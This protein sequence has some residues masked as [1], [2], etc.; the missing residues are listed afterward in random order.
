MPYLCASFSEYMDRN[1]IIGFSLL[2]LLLI[3]Y[4]AYNQHEQKVFFEAKKADSIAYAR[5]HPRPVIDSSRAG[6]TAQP[7]STDSATEALR[8]SQPAAYFGQEQQV[9]LQNKKLSIDFS[10]K[11]AHPVAAKP[12]R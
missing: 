1:Q 5:T 8:R 11:G 3:G 12:H 9:T 6:A 2:A 10:T 4:M 7:V